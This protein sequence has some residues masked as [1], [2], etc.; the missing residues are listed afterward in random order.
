VASSPKLFIPLQPQQTP[1]RKERQVIRLTNNRSDFLTSA[2]KMPKD[3]DS[4]DWR[5]VREAERVGM[6]DVNNAAADAARKQ[7]IYG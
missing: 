4:E 6:T 3:R 2:N 7:G 5:R 1:P